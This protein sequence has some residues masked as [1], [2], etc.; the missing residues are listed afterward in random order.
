MQ[1]TSPP[2]NATISCLHDYAFYLFSRVLFVY[3]FPRFISLFFVSFDL[4]R[5]VNVT[6]AHYFCNARINNATRTTLPLCASMSIRMCRKQEKTIRKNWIVKANEWISD[7]ISVRACVCVC[8]CGRER[9]VKYQSG[10]W[11]ILRW[12][13]LCMCISKVHIVCY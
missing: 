10:D 3:F 12:S 2:P 9:M 5:A 4:W 11:T 6:F 1:R 7:W 13:I 8:M